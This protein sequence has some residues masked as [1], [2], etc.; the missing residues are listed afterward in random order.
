MN[1][2]NRR[3]F[4]KKLLGIISLPFIIL[5]GYAS[6]STVKNSKKKIVKYPLKE[7]KEG[8]NSIKDLLIIKHKDKITVLSK[9]CT[10]LGCIV[11][12]DG[13]QFICPCHGSI[14]DKNGEVV[15]GP[16]NR[17]LAELSYKT[18]NEM[19]IIST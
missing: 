18:N 11:N 9:K 19:I 1:K 10:H 13:N 16:A 17:E 7:L 2:T 6:E 5:W 12:T 14:Y 8:A 3:F 4:I 15:K